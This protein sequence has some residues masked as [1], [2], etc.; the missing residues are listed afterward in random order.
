MRKIRLKFNS[1]TEIVG[2]D[3][4]GL[5]I[6]TDE[7]EKRQL[8]IP[9]DR[10]VMEEFTLRFQRVPVGHLL[11]PEVLWQVIATQTDHDFELII[12]DLIE[13][14]YRVQLYNTRTL[15]P[16]AVRAVDAVLLSYISKIP[17]FIEEQL[18][19]KQ[20]VPF[21]TGATGVSLPVN[22]VSDEM[23]RKALDKA[24]TDENYELASHLR[25]ELRKRNLTGQ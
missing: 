7:E 21:Q 14:Q 15:E 18:M 6:L 25:D 1:L 5:L 24:V 13:G 11:L 12:T 16:I 20:S 19:E 17:L 10:H 4:V 3:K 8:T 23:L 9:C 2:S 22:V